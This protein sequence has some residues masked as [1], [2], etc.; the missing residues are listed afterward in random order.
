MFRSIAIVLTVLLISG[1]TLLR[2]PW[3]LPTAMGG[4]ETAWMPD[5]DRCFWFEPDQQLIC[6]REVSTWFGRDIVPTT[7]TE[8][9]D[10]VARTT[11]F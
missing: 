9:K 10:G 11:A 5:G 4:H 3:A 2:D 7:M 1:V 6:Y 8:V